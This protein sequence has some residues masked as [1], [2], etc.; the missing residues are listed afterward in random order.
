MKQRTHIA[1]CLLGSA[2]CSSLVSAAAAAAELELRVLVVATGDATEDP[3]RELMERTLAGLGVP[4]DVLDTSREEL[5]PSR[6]SESPDR[7]RYNGIILT[8]SQTYLPGRGTGLDAA[9]FALL[10]DY[11]RRF[12]VR[13]A[14][15][16]GF[17]ATSSN[18]GLDYGMASV[19]WGV[20][21]PAS[22]RAP[23]GGTELFEYVNVRSPLPT[24][25]FAFS[26]R[27]RT[28]GSGPLVEPLLVDAENPDFAFVSRL[29]YADGRQVLLCTLNNAT[30]F[31]HSSV[32]AYEFVSY[33]TSGLFIG[34]RHVY[35]SIHNDDLFLADAVWNPATNSDYP[36]SEHSYRWGADEVPLVVA[37]Q[38]RFRRDHPLARDVVIELAFNGAGADPEN[39]PLTQA[40]VAHAS[41]FEFI[42]HTYQALQMDHLCTGEDEDLLCTPTDYDTAFDEIERNGERW[43]ELGLPYP[44]RAYISLLTDSHSGI[45]DRRGTPDTTDDVPFPEG[46]NDELGAAAQALGIRLLAGDASRR[47]QSAIQRV[48]GHDLVLLPRYPT[49]VFFN[50]TNPTE[51]TSE[52]N[53]IFHGR[54]VDEGLDP[55]E[56]PAALC[57]PRTYDEIL[58]AEA[59]LT[60]RHMLA[61]E[62]FPHYFHQSNLHVYDEAG[63]ILQLDWLEHVM[64]AYEQWMVL[65]VESPRFHELADIAWN[66]VLARERTPLGVLDTSS[67]TVTL[68]ASGELSLE[69]TGVAGG[70]LHGG[71][72]IREVDVSAAAITLDVDPALDR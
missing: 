32:L 23:A 60:L 72:S 61:F 36:L 20:D 30:F 71:Q 29:S 39:D 10:H 48:P 55:C 16:S 31:L 14:V 45:E 26:G 42:N 4:Y 66:T 43:L 1:L 27:P 68:T 9:E 8:E 28:D 40:I 65:P 69:V 47:N 17:P 58:D 56:I 35:L 5:L 44:E 11:E 41:D 54:Y 12:G 24:Q 67:G 15:L 34:A 46:F 13:E 38:E 50:T 70:R 21:L 51:L 37:A 63:H 33:A 7:G 19:S 49:A 25:G 6:L 57:E 53:Y 62:P 18:L 2:F 3:G 22:W 59:E 52:Y 64:Q